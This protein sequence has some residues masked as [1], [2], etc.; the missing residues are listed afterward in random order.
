HGVTVCAIHGTHFTSYVKFLR[1]IGTPYAIITDGDPSAGP[2]KTGVDRARKI[3]DAIGGNLATPEKYG[4]FCGLNTLE[5]DLYDA[6]AEN[7]DTMVGALLSF[8]F[9]DTKRKRIA[10]DH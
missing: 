5:A 9:G 4:I 10:R 7:A 1:A 6:S 3:V 2:G 8:E